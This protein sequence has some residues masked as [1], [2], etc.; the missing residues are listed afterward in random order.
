MNPKGAERASVCACWPAAAA[1]PGAIETMPIDQGQGQCPGW[2]GV[3]GNTKRR[4]GGTTP[5]GFD[6][7]KISPP[8][9]HTGFDTQ[10]SRRQQ[11][12]T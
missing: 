1:P 10:G 2:P 5:A 7:H 6:A 4:G 12:Q 11:N 9:A 3:G 8:D